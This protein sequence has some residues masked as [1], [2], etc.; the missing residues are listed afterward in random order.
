MQCYSVQCIVYTV[1]SYCI[2][3]VLFGALWIRACCRRQWSHYE[4][5]SHCSRNILPHP[6]FLSSVLFLDTFGDLDPQIWAIFSS[7]ST[8]LK[9]NSWSQYEARKHPFT[10]RLCLIFGYILAIFGSFLL[11]FF[12]LLECKC[13]QCLICIQ[14]HHRFVNRLIYY[15]SFW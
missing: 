7:K 15:Q 8:S 14:L 11:Y 5:M 13:V 6:P 9:I 2:V 4:R 12:A 1:Y 3:Y 10:F